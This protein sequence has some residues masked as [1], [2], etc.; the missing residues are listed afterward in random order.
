MIGFG[1]LGLCPNAPP[2][3]FP[4]GPGIAIVAVSCA[5]AI[6]TLHLPSSATGGGRLRSLWKPSGANPLSFAWI[7][8]ILSLTAPFVVQ[9]FPAGTGS[10]S[11]RRSSRNN[12]H[13][14]PPIPFFRACFPPPAHILA[15]TPGCIQ[16][17]TIPAADFRHLNPAG[18]RFSSLCEI[19]KKFVYQV[20]T[21]RLQRSII[22]VW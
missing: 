2:K 17:F 10:G 3:G 15:M 8:R 14:Y 6:P 19:S 20:L 21:K 4:I 18:K 11:R 13:F 5:V 1:S 7:V 12:P 16:M 9:F 22:F